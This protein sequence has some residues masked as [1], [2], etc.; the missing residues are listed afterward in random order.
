MTSIIYWIWTEGILIFKK[1]IIYLQDLNAGFF[2]Y[3]QDF[4]DLFAG[5]L[6]AGFF[7]YLQ[8]PANSQIIDS[9]IDIFLFMKNDI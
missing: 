9:W 2:G 8:D 3:L 1:G 4:Y 6:F 5:Y 7:G